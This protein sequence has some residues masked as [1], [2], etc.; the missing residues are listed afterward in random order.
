MAVGI[1]LN[2][3]NTDLIQ[4]MEVINN[5]FIDIGYKSM[6]FSRVY[7]GTI[8]NN[9]IQ[10]GYIGIHYGTSYE[11]ARI[12]N[13]RIICRQKGINYYSAGYLSEPG[14]I[15]NNYIF[16]TDG[17]ARGLSIG[18]H[19]PVN[20]YY[21]TVILGDGGRDAHAFSLSNFPGDNMVN[22]T[23]NIFACLRGGYPYYNS[24]PHNP[25]D[26]LDYNCYYTAGQF[27][28]NESGK[29][30]F[31]LNELRDYLGKDQH[32]F[33][34]Y[35]VFSPDTSVYPITNWVNNKGIP[36]SQVATDID[37]KPRDETNPD[38]GAAEFTPPSYVTPPYSGDYTI[39][40]GADFDSLAQAIDSLLLKGVSS[41]V[42]LNFSS[43][44]HV[45]HTEIP[46]IPGT[47]YDKHLVLQSG[48]GNRDDVLIKY[49][50]QSNTDNGYVIT[51]H[52]TDF[53]TVRN[54]S[55]KAGRVEGP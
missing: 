53:M 50:E 1:Y 19:S 33:T 10:G 6:F 21:N 13:N 20:I 32:S 9:E 4:E 51:C 15:A 41:E 28:G 29:K 43:G 3:R 55:F 31:N 5:Q 38:V 25:L 23:N 12:Q 17:G 26:T 7:H 37:G 40:P 2:G 36:I 16:I 48:S 34:A 49:E 11:R 47:D 24:Y 45:V 18:G 44:T 27:I 52:G 42:R 14:L 35:P 22:V 8:Q 30:L 39:G 46:S 54:L